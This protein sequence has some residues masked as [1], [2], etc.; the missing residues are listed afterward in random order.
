MTKKRYNIKVPIVSDFQSLDMADLKKILRHVQKYELSLANHTSLEEET[1]HKNILIQNKN[2]EAKA[3]YQ[4]FTNKHCSPITKEV[5]NIWDLIHA[6]RATFLERFLDHDVLL[7]RHYKLSR[8]TCTPL[9]E[10]LIELETSLDKIMEQAPTFSVQRH[11]PLPAPP[12][13]EVNLKISGAT[14]KVQLHK[15]KSSDVIEIIDQKI[16]GIDKEKQKINVLKARAASTEKEIRAQAQGYR[17][18]FKKQTNK[19]PFC[20]Y[21]GE[22]FDEESTPHLDHIYPVSKGGK[23]SASNLVFVC[24]TCNLNKSAL[25]LRSFIIKYKLNESLIHENLEL[26]G[27][28]F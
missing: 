2:D 5:K 20:P 7:F 26:L 4:E 19:I 14:F 21:C 27:K 10:K 6:N 17:H 22:K 9:V 15:T 16:A 28:D 11:L 18:G 24:T 3:R 13:R 8:K 1:K 12:Q 23:S 25:T